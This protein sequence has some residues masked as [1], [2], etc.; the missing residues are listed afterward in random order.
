MRRVLGLLVALGVLLA[1]PFVLRRDDGG[2]G[3]PRRAAAALVIITPHNEAIRA[4]F[5]A[6]FARW[7]EERYG[8]AVAVDWV[9]IGGTSEIGRYLPGEFAA[10]VR[11]WWRAQGR[12][13]PAGGAEA[14]FQRA[15]PEDAAAAALWDAFRATDDAAAFH[16]GIDL[17][18]GGGE[19]DFR[20]AGEQGLTVEP[21]PEGPPPGLFTTADGRVLIP[22]RMNGENWCGP[23]FFGSVLTTFG[24]SFNYDRL[25]ELG[26]P[27]PQ[28]WADLTDPRYRGQLGLADP[29]K[30]GSSA[31]AFD[32]MIQEQMAAAAHA[33]G[34]DDAAIAAQEAAAARAPAY[35]AALARGW[36]AG[37]HLIQRLGANARYFTAASQ[38]VPFEVGMGEVAAG[39]CVDFYGRFQA[40][41]TP[42]GA[43][44]VGFVAPRGG[45]A[46]TSDPIALLRGARHRVHALRFLEFCLGEAG[47]RLWAYR[48]G[49]PGGPRQYA[50]RRLPIRRDFY[51]SEDPEFQ[52]AYARHAPQLADPLGGEA[53]AYALTA[54]FA[55]HARWTGPHFA[56]HRDLVRAMCIDS[57]VE[58]QAAWKAIVRHGGPE[59]NP[60]AMAALRRLPDRPEP[61][62]WA[63]APALVKKYPRLEYLR[64]WTACFRENYRAA[65]AL[66][67]GRSSP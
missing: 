46:V 9:V 27:P 54:A 65:A 37:I 44:R 31:R 62:T 18:F 52:A 55:T 39:V 51:P 48:A 50:L 19:Y 8:E 53:N 30:S 4:E 33:A 3:P 34:F 25:A 36:E 61:L 63:S 29:T 14:L 45:T 15:R 22:A 12:A 10:A 41:F 32:L 66:A 20:I 23:G 60:E 58:L 17:F 42:G 21:W 7:H 24:I 11:A 43:R 28:R 5:G 57:A 38:R 47:Q 59:A 13:W 35:E 16:C 6:A 49:T 56:A 1:L 40:Q 26:L 64:A 2:G 67:G